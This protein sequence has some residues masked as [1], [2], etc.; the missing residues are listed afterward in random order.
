MEFLDSGNLIYGFWREKSKKAVK[1]RFKME[2][3]IL[4]AGLGK[5]EH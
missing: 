1:W 4:Q 3:P 2:I 5:D